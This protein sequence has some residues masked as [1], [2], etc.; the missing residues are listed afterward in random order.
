MSEPLYEPTEAEI[1]ERC[2]AIQRE[3]DRHERRKRAGA[4][5]VPMAVDVREV[6]RPVLSDSRE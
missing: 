2:L 6:R 1:R 3:W 4:N 5:Y